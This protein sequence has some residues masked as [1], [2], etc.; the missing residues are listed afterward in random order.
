MSLLG[1][2]IG[3]TGCKAAA[4]SEDGACLAQAY[5][6]YSVRH[7][8]NGWAELDSHD[9]WL[10]VR[11][12]IAETAAA[13]QPDPVSALCASSLGEAMVPVSAQREIR[14]NA[15]LCLDS[16]GAEYVQ[17][18]QTQM[19]QE[20][21]YRLN[22]NILGTEYALPKLLWL[23]E[24]D[25][26]AY[27]A[28]DRFLLWG[29]MV[30]FMLGCEPVTANSLANRTLLFDLARDDW[31][32]PLLQWSGIG[33]DRLGRVQRGGT[34]A[35]IVSPSA[36][37]E[38]GLPAGVQVVVGGHDQCCNA[39]GTG[40]IEAGSAV[41]GIGTFE[42]ITPAYARVQDPLSMLRQGLNIEHHVL[43]GLFV[44]FIF[45]QGGM[46]VKWFRDTFAADR[47]SGNGDVYD[48][49]NREM[50]D[51]P[52]RLLTLPHFEPPVSPRHIPDSAG[53]ILGLK[54]TTTRGEI[55]KSIMECETLYFADSIRALRRM[56]IDT[57]RFIASG[58]GA[59]SDAWLQ[60]KADVFGVPFVRPRVTEGSVLGAAMLAGQAT[61]VFHSPGEAVET[62][63]KTD[64]V[65]TPDDARHAVYQEKLELY[66]DILPATHG[67]LKRLT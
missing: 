47:T 46:L 29:D 39:L 62:F 21:F 16:R 26:N 1:I 4:F 40:C 61:G 33:R 51:A 38:L 22:P 60:I 9:V 65:F 8:R 67:L 66:R 63:V 5:R 30:G 10:K 45:N 50:P 23:R 19:G 35:G 43:P 20:A 6:E 28:A 42:C 44:S 53:V 48:A 37:A 34:L 52:T 14:G 64:R 27:S 59:R 55:L 24:H 17:A 11:E 15:I 49:L 2:D 7:P 54:S 31:A 12:T 25:P 13:T 32:D 58:G 56:G 57:T 41:C 18:L 36:A 3:T